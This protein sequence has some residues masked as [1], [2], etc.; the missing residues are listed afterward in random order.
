[1][2][3]NKTHKHIARVLKERRLANGWTQKQFAEKAGVNTN[4]Y[5]KVERNLQKASVDT[6]EKLAKAL[7]LESKDILPF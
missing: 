4:G 2:S 6:L 1:M 5:A 7:K 3:T